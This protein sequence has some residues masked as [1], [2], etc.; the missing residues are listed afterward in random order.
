MG[1]DSLPRHISV[2]AGESLRLNLVALGPAS[3]ELEISLD[4]E[5]AEL[6]AAGLYVCTGRD[7]VNIRLNVRHNVPGCTSRQLFKGLV[8][9]ESK[10]SFDGLVYVAHGAVR[11]KAAQENHTI[12]LSRDAVAESRPQLEI[13]ADDVECSHGATTGFLDIDEQFYM[14][15]RGIPEAEARRLQ[16]ISF[17]SPVLSRLEGELQKEVV[18][19]IQ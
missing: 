16:M 9:G 1:K 15:S 17:I 19:M 10:A 11:T 5:G 6:D 4:G 7:Q 18:K 8:G 2:A 3:L 13:Y 12:L 14:R